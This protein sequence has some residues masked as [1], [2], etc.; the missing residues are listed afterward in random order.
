MCVIGG[1]GSGQAYGFYA[2]FVLWTK[3]RTHCV[4][5]HWLQQLLRVSVRTSFVCFL[6]VF[7]FLQLVFFRWLSSL[8]DFWH[9][10]I[11]CFSLCMHSLAN[12]IQFF[13]LIEFFELI[14]WPSLVDSFIYVLRVVEPRL[15]H[16][17]CFFIDAVVESRSANILS[18][19]SLGSLRICRLLTEY[20]GM[21]QF[22]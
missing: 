9:D 16:T 10:T 4:I 13:V 2:A 3:L 21:F 17:V 5:F 15:S 22:V 14:E 8:E 6:W 19:F 18:V 7:C 12:P 11:E 20:D 1:M